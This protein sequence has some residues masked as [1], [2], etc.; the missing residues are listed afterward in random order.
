MFKIQEYYNI[1]MDYPELYQTGAHGRTIVWT[2][3]VEQTGDEVAIV[4]RYGELDGRRQTHRRIVAEGRAKRTPLE[5]AMFEANKKWTDKKEKE[6]YVAF[7]SLAAPAERSKRDMRPMLAQ[8][9]DADKRIPWPQMV[10][11]K[12][13]GVRCMAFIDRGEIILNS[14]RGVEF[15]NL[16]HIRSVLRPFLERYPDMILDGELYADTIS[17][18][19]I[20]GLVKRKETDS[21]VDR[22]IY[23]MIYDVIL[24]NHL[25]ATYVTRLEWLRSNMPDHASVRLSRTETAN[26]AAAA[27]R[28]HDEFVQEGYEGLILRNMAGPYEL[29]KRSRYLLKMKQFDE[30]EFRIIGFKESSGEDAGTVIWQIDA[31]G[32]Q[33]WVKQSGPREIRR[34]MFEE[35]ERYLGKMLTVSF[36]GR[37]DDGSLRFPVGKDIRDM[38]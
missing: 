19:E 37:T 1:K 29:D 23:Y 21:P 20:T 6:N 15:Y 2:I 11:P 12:Y 36:F 7:S 38:Y 24:L 31:G 33:V 16:N 35:G 25:D 18:Q 14:R 34:R 32:V 4:T 13:D 27:R 17:F 10:Q 22:Q 28:F 9:Y 30:E 3:S 8:T 5:Q 26:N